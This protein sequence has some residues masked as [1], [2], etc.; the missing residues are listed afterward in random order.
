MAA[1]RSRA[2][3]PSTPRTPSPGPTSRSPATRTRAPASSASGT[4]AD[5][6]GPRLRPDARRGR[7]GPA[8]Q[9]R[10]DRQPAVARRCCRRAARPSCDSS[11][12]MPPTRTRRPRPS[13]ATCV[14]R[15][16]TSPSSP[17]RC[18]RTPHARQQP[19]AC[20]RRHA[21]LQLL[22]PTARSWSSP[23]RRRVP[24]PH[25]LANPLGHGAVVQNDGEIFSF[26]GNAQQNGLTPCNL[27]TV[28]VAGARQRH[29]CRRS[30]RPAG[31]I[32]PAS[33][34]CGTPD[35]VHETVYGRGYATFAMRREG[36]ELE[37]TVFV[38]PDA[39]G[40]DPAAH[41]PQPDARREAL[42]R[43]A[44]CRDGAGRVC[45]R[46]PGPPAWSAP[47]PSAGPSTSRN[48]RNDFHQ[49]LGVR[50]HDAARRGAGACPRPLRR[51][52]RA[53]T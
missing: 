13:R 34:R 36:L 26:A 22:A 43:R 7:R 4:L 48:P 28:P 52:T 32:R 49:R 8:L 37:L 25:V 20:E 12:A 29:L 5:A 24:G 16:P 42:P 33:R 30:R 41:D 47:T 46:H 1:T 17:R 45:A 53:A 19:A 2:R 9:L 3:S 23:A 51:R 11:T 50:G 6:G 18:A 38:P 40:R 35:A 10:P 39:A 14:G 21:A 31:S 44:L 27:D 15:R